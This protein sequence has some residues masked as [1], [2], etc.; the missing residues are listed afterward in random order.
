MEGQLPTVSLRERY[1]S[2]VSSILTTD[3]LPSSTHVKESSA[4]LYDH[5]KNLGGRFQKQK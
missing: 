3:M 1:Q 2:N 5:V 4:W